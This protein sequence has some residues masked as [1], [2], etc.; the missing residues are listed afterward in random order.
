MASTV[1]ASSEARSE[2]DAPPDVPVASS[3]VKPIDEDEQ[4]STDLADWPSVLTD[5]TRV[6]LVRRGPYEVHTPYQLILS[7]FSAFGCNLQPHSGPI[8][9]S[10]KSSLVFLNPVVHPTFGGF[11]NP[12]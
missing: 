6:E 5:K 2:P 9:S 12:T 4:L 8:E 7:F 1:Q 10:L 11:P 3:S